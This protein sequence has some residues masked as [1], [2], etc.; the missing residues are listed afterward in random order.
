MVVR[1][2]GGAGKTRVLSATEGSPLGPQGRRNRGQAEL[3]F[4]WQRGASPFACSAIQQSV[5]GC[6][7]Q[8]RGEE[9]PL[10]SWLLWCPKPLLDQPK[11]EE[12]PSPTAGGS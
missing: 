2:S 11:M 3:L 1:Y 9:L 12:R 8:E 6:E 5:G 10:D 7:R 4:S